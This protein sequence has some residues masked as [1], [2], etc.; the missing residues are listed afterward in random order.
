[1]KALPVLLEH[2]GP[3][4][5]KIPLGLIWKDRAKYAADLCRGTPKI[6]KKLWNLYVKQI[7]IWSVLVAGVNLLY[8]HWILDSAIWEDDLL[9]QS[10][11]IPHHCPQ[12]FADRHVREAEIIIFILFRHCVTFTTTTFGQPLIYRNL[13]VKDKIR[14]ILPHLAA[15]SG[16]ASVICRRR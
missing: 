3:H 8:F 10:V 5:L 6:W 9:P 1:M 7:K 2:W 12:L 15:S 16:K 13:K 14:P 4:L 11:G